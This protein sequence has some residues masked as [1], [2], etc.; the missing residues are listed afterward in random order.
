MLTESR[1][2]AEFLL[3][4]CYRLTDPVSGGDLAA[5]AQEMNDGPV[6]A[7]VKLPAANLTAARM[8]QLFGFRRICAQVE[9]RCDLE[10]S[11]PDTFQSTVDEIAITDSLFLNS[12]DIKSHAAN[13]ETNRYRQDPLLDWEAANNLY[14]RWVSNSLS[15]R[16]RVAHVARDFCS[17]LDAGEV[18]SIDLLSVLDKRQGHAMRLVHA[19]IEDARGRGLAEV[20]VVTEVENEIALKVYR[21]AGFQINTFLRVS[22]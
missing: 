1:F 2:D 21:R 15:G 16:K 19:V 20:R 11:R 8:L 18:R 6:F 3:L 4:P 10:R 13:F 14:A 12:N 5:L 7:D 22:I 17:F 9:L